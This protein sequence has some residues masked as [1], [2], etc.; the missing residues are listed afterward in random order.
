MKAVG[1]RWLLAAV[2]QGTGPDFVGAEV[3]CL[4]DSSSAVVVVMV[5]VA[6]V[7]VVADV[8]EEEDE[9]WNKAYH[10]DH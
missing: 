4:G 10:G 6:A 7:V 9:H 3:E 5:V 2:G 1:A 8:V